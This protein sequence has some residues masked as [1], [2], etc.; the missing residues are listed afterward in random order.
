MIAK[1]RITVLGAGLVGFPIALDL[2]K[3]EKLE[4]TIHDIRKERLDWIREKHDQISTSTTERSNGNPHLLP[5]NGED[6]RI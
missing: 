3:D 2:S 6:C 4:V 1:S 5:G